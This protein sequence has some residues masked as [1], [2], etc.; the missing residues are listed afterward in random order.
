MTTEKKLIKNKL[1]WLQLLR[2]CKMYP[3]RAGCRKWDPAATPFIG[4][5]R[6]RRKAALKRLGKRAVSNPTFETGYRG[7]RD[8]FYVGTLKGSGRI[9][10]QAFVDTYAAVAL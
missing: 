7:S 6:P 5:K 10:Q 1:G 9:Y 2:I 8:I 4:S 3:K